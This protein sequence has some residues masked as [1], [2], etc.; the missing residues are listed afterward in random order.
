M[1]DDLLK[2]CG[3]E[4]EEI[5]NEAPRIEKAFHILGIDSADADRS[6][7]HIRRYED[8]GLTGYRMMRGVGVRELTNLVLAREERLV[9]LCFNYFLGF[10]Q[11]F[12][13][14]A[15]VEFTILFG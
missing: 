13:I 6:A 10:H 12:L 9:N 4:P 5:K 15:H 11:F 1:Y 3:F 8:A 7:E 14:G 2:L